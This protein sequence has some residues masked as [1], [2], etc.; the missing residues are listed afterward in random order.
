M[1]SVVVIGQSLTV[2]EHRVAITMRNVTLAVTEIHSR[3]HYAQGS[4]HWEEPLTEH[5][6]AINV[7]NVTLA[8]T[9]I[10]SS[11][12]Y[13]QGSCHRAEPVTEHRVAITAQCNTSC[14]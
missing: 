10:H 12:H 11:Y 3:Y 1:R 2:T 4:C 6:V 9:E 5:R 14:H 7:R 8:V 13:T